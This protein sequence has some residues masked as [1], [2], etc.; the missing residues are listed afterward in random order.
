MSILFGEEY[1]HD[2]CPFSYCVTCLFITAVQELFLCSLWGSLVG[3][4]VSRSSSALDC[5]VFLSFEDQG[6]LSVFFLLFYEDTMENTVMSLTL[7]QF[8]LSVIFFYGW[9]FLHFLSGIF[10]CPKVIK[11]FSCL[12]CSPFTSWP[13]ICLELTWMYGVRLAHFFL[14]RT[15]IYWKGRLSPTALHVTFALKQKPAYACVC[16]WTLLLLF[17]G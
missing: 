3:C 9:Y 17:V 1:I 12:Y 6:A 13:A 10:A 15:S 16:S 4:V 8:S 14:I 2:F 11:A 5:L 7:K